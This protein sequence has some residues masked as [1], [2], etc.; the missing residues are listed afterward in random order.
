MRLALLLTLASL[1]LAGLVGCAVP[2]APRT[3]QPADA[4]A[5]RA[6]NEAYAAAWVANDS[7]AVMALFA[8]DAVL[9]PHHGDPPVLGRDA[10]RV[11]FWRPGAAPYTVTRYRMTPTE[12]QGEG[13][14]AVSWGRMNLALTW[15]GEDGP[16]IYENAGN[17]LM[18]FRRDAAGTWRITRFIWNDPVVL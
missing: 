10:I 3:F 9:I 1:A 11:H 15:E 6:V 12:V 17:Y 4:V 5:V 8:D 16:A 2:E 14:L 7:A 18:T 13:E